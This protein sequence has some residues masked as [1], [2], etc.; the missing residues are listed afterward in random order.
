MT[1]IAYFVRRM[2]EYEAHLMGSPADRKA[3]DMRQG[4][5]NRRALAELAP[6]D[7]KRARLQALIDAEPVDL[8]S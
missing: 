5:F 8:F 2:T 7:P 3:L 6:D 1:D 4:I